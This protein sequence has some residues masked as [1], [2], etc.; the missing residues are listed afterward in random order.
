MWQWSRA[1]ILSLF[2]ERE[3]CVSAALLCV[4]VCVCVCVCSNSPVCNCYESRWIWFALHASLLTE[5]TEASVCLSVRERGCLC[6]HV[7]KQLS[8][9]WNSGYSV[10][11]FCFWHLHLCPTNGD[12][13]QGKYQV[14][15]FPA[16]CCCQVWSL[17]ATWTQFIV[18]PIPLPVGGFVLLF[19]W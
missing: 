6:S 5:L 15:C 16:S 4:C 8:A 7:Q 11:L 14:F 9:G 19:L 1:S 18:Y 12:S 17:N 13:A 2:A 10:C 3:R